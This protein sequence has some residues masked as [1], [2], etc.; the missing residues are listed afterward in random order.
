MIQTNPGVALV[1]GASAGIGR[2]SAK[3]L[4]DARYRVDVVRE[5]VF[6]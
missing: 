2:A 1:T 5:H 6:K 3:A 4:Q